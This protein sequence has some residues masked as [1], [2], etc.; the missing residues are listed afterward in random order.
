MVF[1][2]LSTMF[3]SYPGGQFYWWRKQ[4]YTEKTSDLPQVTDKCYHIM[5]YRVNLVWAGF[6]L[7]LVV[8]DTDFIGSCKSNYHTITITT[9]MA[10]KLSSWS[11][12]LF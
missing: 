5:L 9:T 8:I 12:W 4:E 3:Q 10:P 7:T 11:G 1:T 6:E 2:A